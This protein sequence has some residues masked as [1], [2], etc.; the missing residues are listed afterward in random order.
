MHPLIPH[1]GT[2]KAK[3]A[4]FQVK[5]II[6]AACICNR[7]NDTFIRLA[8]LYIEISM[9]TAP[10]TPMNLQELGWQPAFSQALD[11]RTEPGLVPARVARQNRH[12]YVV[13]AE[14]GALAAEVSGKMRD[15]AHTRAAFPAVG[16]WVAVAA[17]PDEGTATIH[18]VLPRKSHFSR[19]VAGVTTEEQVVAANVDTVFLVSGLDHDFNLRRIE[20][21]LTL[22]WNSG[23]LPVIVLNKADL[24][25]DLEG[26]LVAV[27]AV[28][29]GIDILPVSAATGEGVDA[30]R[31]YL[32]P[33]QTVA[34]LGSSGVGKST[35]VN[36][37][38]GEERMQTTDVREDDS[39]GRHTTTF[40][41]LILLPEGGVMIDTPGMRE[42][43]LWADEESL[44][45]AFA[46]IETL[47]QDCHFRDCAH[48]TEPGCAVRAALDAGV[49]DEGRFHSY[50]KLKRELARLARR[51]TE[52]GRYEERQR[53]KAFGR[54]V[55]EIMKHNRKR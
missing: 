4:P 48:D 24:C 26:R 23:A 27:E 36:R 21:Y 37:L 20:R 16:D 14:A 54:M 45:A 44:H 31:A 2:G 33:G 52:A 42:L 17:R 8:Y 38:L 15:A 39:R 43:Q 55:K 6:L 1:I 13:F 32:A 29:M 18:A 30:L 28:A 46:D 5:A 10:L 41:E 51:Q 53:D 34:F 19:K 3:R 40:R 22:A 49:L 50:L 35:L 47:A 12:H 9:D 25:D 11:K 7:I